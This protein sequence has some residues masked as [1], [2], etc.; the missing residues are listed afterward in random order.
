MGSE[1]PLSAAMPALEAALSK[2]ASQSD[3]VEDFESEEASLKCLEM[4]AHWRNNIPT[5]TSSEARALCKQDIVLPAKLALAEDHEKKATRAFA[6]SNHCLTVR[7]AFFKLWVA[8]MACQD[9]NEIH[10]LFGDLLLLIKML[11][12]SLTSRT[13][14]QRF[15]LMAR[16]ASYL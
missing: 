3:L 13:K 7:K 6:N 10:D 9:V 2:K 11:L 4:T 15:S 16:E 14:R 8:R 1:S 5:V 12:L